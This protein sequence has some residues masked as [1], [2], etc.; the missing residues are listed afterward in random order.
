MRCKRNRE[1]KR[2]RGYVIWEVVKERSRET[3]GGKKIEN[4]GIPDIT[5]GMR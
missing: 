3:A 2:G 4:K 1:E 5:V